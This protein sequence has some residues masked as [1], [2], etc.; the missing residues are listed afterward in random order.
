MTP[1]AQSGDRRLSTT[2]INR[3]VLP[4]A[5]AACFPGFP[6]GCLTL[7]TA[8]KYSCPVEH[9]SFISIINML[10][11]EFCITLEQCQNV[12][13]GEFADSLAAFNGCIGE[14]TLCFL[15]LEDTLFDAVV[16][17]EAVDCD[18]D[19]LVEAMDSVDGLLFYELR[20]Y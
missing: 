16:D 8:L 18:I 2:S 9:C 1:N 5:Q 14:F 6:S 19:R 12:F 17:G 4:K 15:Q 7:F 10:L 11:I 3:I 13:H 20:A